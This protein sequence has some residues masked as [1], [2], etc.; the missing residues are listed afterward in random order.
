[1][2]S[3]DILA[4]QIALARTFGVFC[5]PA[6]AVAYAGF[7]QVAA[8]DTSPALPPPTPLLPSDRVVLLLTG[9]GLKDPK[10]AALGV[11]YVSDVPAATSAHTTS[12]PAESSSNTKRAHTL[13][14]VKPNDI[15]AVRAFA[16]KEC[17]L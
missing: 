7:L 1:M 14:I 15:A 6:A 16:V 10:S 4:A 17:L 11:G 9:H 2:M 5:E 12:A 3:A 8:A 13:C